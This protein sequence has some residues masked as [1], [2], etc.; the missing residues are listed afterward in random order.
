MVNYDIKKCIKVFL[1]IVFLSS[2]TMV[3]NAQTMQQYQTNPYSSGTYL[4]NN[5]NIQQNYQ[6]N[7]QLN[8]PYTSPNATNETYPTEKESPMKKVWNVIQGLLNFL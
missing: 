7:N 2:F 3:I 8:Y 4:Q 1:L 6:D 5:N